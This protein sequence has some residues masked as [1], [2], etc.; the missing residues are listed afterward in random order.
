MELVIITSL[1]LIALFLMCGGRE[2][3]GEWLVKLFPK[4]RLNEHEKVHIYLNGEYNRTAGIGSVSGDKLYIYGSVP[5]PLSY[6][7]RFYSV[8][9]DTNDG[10]KLVYVAFHR[11]YKF[12]RMAE[13]IRCV[14]NVCNDEEQLPDEELKED[15]NNETEI[16]DEE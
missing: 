3:V 1:V 15:D 8:G 16:E 2:L 4:E 12:V 9:Y 14:F 11:H 13:M 10:S 7:G 5:L 6:R